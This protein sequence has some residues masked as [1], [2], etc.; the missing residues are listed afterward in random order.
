M[1]RT[2]DARSSSEKRA[3]PVSSRT[4]QR[5]VSPEMEFISRTPS[6]ELRLPAGSLRRR[7]EP[8]DSLSESAVAV[9]ACRQAGSAT[10]AHLSRISLAT[11]SSGESGPPLSSR[12]RRKVASDKSSRSLCRTPSIE[13]S[14]RRSLRIRRDRDSSPWTSTVARRLRSQADSATLGYPLRYPS[15]QHRPRS[16]LRNQPGSKISSRTRRQTGSMTP[17]H[18]A[19]SS[20][21]DWSSSVSSRTWSSICVTRRPPT[22]RHGEDL[23]DT[24]S[25]NVSPCEQPDAKHPTSQSSPHSLHTSSSCSGSGSVRVDSVNEGVHVAHA[26]PRRRRLL[27]AAEYWKRTGSRH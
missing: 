18:H 22:R 4:R 19:R 20:R 27:R 11:S 17:S 13:W 2:P 24:Q 7:R 16:S 6:I 23:E 10:T 26:A 5:A 15:I 21:E 1:M 9:R 14:P 8:D 25:L 3:P 12:T